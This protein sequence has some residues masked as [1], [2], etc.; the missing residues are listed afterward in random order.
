MT[1]RFLA[2][3]CVPNSL[4]EALRDAGHQVFRLREH[5]PADSPD[6]VVI[7]E[8]QKLEC[9]LLSLDSDFADIVAYPP[10]KYR[11]IIAFQV[12]N[13]PETILK[14]VARL[15]DYLA[16]NPDI[17]HYRGKLFVV[18]ADRIRVRE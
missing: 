11:G 1:L 13:R 10:A 15:K 8:A 17:N 4:I 3:Q 16:A 14:L 2:D 9:I 5:L 6:P 7:L 12:R 18:E